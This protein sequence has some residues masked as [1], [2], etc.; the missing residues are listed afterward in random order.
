MQEHA[1]LLHAWIKLEL[2]DL[3]PTP[4][5]PI[6]THAPS[7]HQPDLQQLSSHAEALTAG[8][9]EAAMLRPLWLT[10]SAAAAAS[11]E[12]ATAAGLRELVRSWRAQADDDS[13]EFEAELLGLDALFASQTGQKLQ[14]MMKRNPVQRMIK[15]TPAAHP[16]LRGHPTPTPIKEFHPINTP[17]SVKAPHSIKTPHHVKAQGTTAAGVLGLASSLQL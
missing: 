15:G 10:V 14:V 17:H 3:Q 8:K 9:P 7:N 6:P 4:P 11:S 2:A 12:A 5:Y 13:A 16:T 1:A